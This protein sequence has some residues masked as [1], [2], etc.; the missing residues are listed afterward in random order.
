MKI[1]TKL[2][3]GGL[4]F[5]SNSKP[6]LNSCC[7]NQEPTN[8]T[9]NLPWR[10]I[11]IMWWA[12]CYT[13]VHAVQCTSAEEWWNTTK[14]QTKEI[15]GRG[16]RRESCLLNFFMWSKTILVS[17]FVFFRS[18]QFNYVLFLCLFWFVHR[19]NWMEIS[20]QTWIICV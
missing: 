8:T 13:L 1:L 6:G 7:K 20:S 18:I 3:P 4:P 15:N 14:W 2:T 11:V 9:L 19:Y 17:L 10:G 5:F 16:G 12:A